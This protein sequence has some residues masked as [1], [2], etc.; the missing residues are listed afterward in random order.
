MSFIA[1][2]VLWILLRPSAILVLLLIAGS[3]AMRPMRR[4]WGRLILLGGDISSNFN[5]FGTFS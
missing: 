5:S 1:S 2:K 4:R 3:L